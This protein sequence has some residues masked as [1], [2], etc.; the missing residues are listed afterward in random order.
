[1]LDAIGGTFFATGGDADARTFGQFGTDPGGFS[2]AIP[3]VNAGATPGRVGGVTFVQGDAFVES[4][5]VTGI[6]REQD[7]CTRDVADDALQASEGEVAVLE[8]V[9]FE[10]AFGDK[11]TFGGEVVEGTMTAKKNKELVVGAVGFGEVLVEGGLDGFQ[12]RVSDDFEVVKFVVRA[13]L[14]GNGFGVADGVFEVG[15]GVVVLDG[16]EE[17]M[18]FGGA[19]MSGW[20]WRGGS[21]KEGAEEEEKGLTHYVRVDKNL[22]SGVKIRSGGRIKN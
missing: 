20:F 21:Q 16:K 13:Q 22:G 1:M 19:G 7:M 8:R 10:P 14:L 11:K 12:R 17:G 18:V 15:P 3:R 5:G 6:D 9:V 2:I 4:A